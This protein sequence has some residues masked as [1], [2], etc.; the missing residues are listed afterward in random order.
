MAW[1]RARRLAAQA[2]GARPALE[3]PFAQAVG[4]VLAA[5][6]TARNP[7][8]PFDIATS[9]GY[10]VAGPGPWTI[11]TV[12]GRLPDGAA[13]PIQVD[14]ALPHGADAVLPTAYAVV[15]D[16]AEATWLYV[17]DAAS[18]RQSDRPG[19]IPTGNDVRTG[20]QDCPAGGLLAPAGQIVT[21]ALVGIAAS[22]GL[23]TLVVIRPPDVV[24][25]LVGDGRRTRGRAGDG[26]TRD[27][28]TPILADAVARAGGRC[29]PMHELPGP[30]TGA[31]DRIRAVVDDAAADLVLVTGDPGERTRDEVVHAFADLGA[32]GLVGEV[33]MTPGRDG[34][35]VELPDG[36]LAVYVPGDL[37]GALAVL[38]T[39]VVPALRSMA[40]HDDADPVLA[41][42][43]TDL[44]GDPDRTTL[45]PAVRRRGEL[46][47]TAQV[48]RGRPLVAPAVADSYAV[49]PP[50]GASTGQLVELVDLP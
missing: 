14:Q 42:V 13:T 21:P 19:H 10:A 17:G 33:A 18:G 30:V 26:H 43:D 31:A 28:V 39:L 9:T 34:R 16:G 12:E 50:G 11:E 27:S 25:V 40:G 49:V 38:T 32:R 7:L 48:V 6:A 35:L 36:R 45:A 8:P 24:P 5:P 15:R 23:D 22:A 47:D 2:A 41:L 37:P 20:G 44:P 3:V 29:L 46:T 4:L 1:G